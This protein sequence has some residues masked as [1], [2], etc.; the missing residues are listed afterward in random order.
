MIE[1]FIKD[2]THIH[3]EVLSHR[4]SG[5]L[6]DAQ[7]YESRVSDARSKLIKEIESRGYQV[8]L[9]SEFAYMDGKPAVT[10]TKLEV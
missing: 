3:A 10:V 6:A 5:L 9:A 8:G 1:M 7:R 2:L 4:I